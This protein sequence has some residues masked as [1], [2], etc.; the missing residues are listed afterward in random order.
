MTVHKG[1]AW[2]EVKP[3]EQ[4]RMPKLVRIEYHVGGRW[5]MTVDGVE[6]PYYVAEG[7]EVSIDE[8]CPSVALRL[9]AERVEV[10][11]G[12]ADE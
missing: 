6:F 3:M 11:H 5:S 2:V 9:L 8:S 10:V 4:P 1:E 12:M 7:V